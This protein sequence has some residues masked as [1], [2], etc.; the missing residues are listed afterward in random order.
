MEQSVNPMIP[1]GSG[2]ASSSPTPPA[3][4]DDEET[5]DRTPIARWNIIPFQRFSESVSIGVVAFHINGIDRVDF[6]A[7]GGEWVEARGM[8]ENPR[9]GVREYWGTLD[10]SSAAG[11]IEL[12]ALVWPRGSGTPLMLQN[13]I[14]D[15]GDSSSIGGTIGIHSMFLRAGAEEAQAYWVSEHGDD[16]APG[17]EG[18]PL[19]TLQ[20]AAQRLKSS[21]NISGGRIVVASSGVFEAPHQIGAKAMDAWLT[22]EAADGIDRDSIVIIPPGYE[23]GGDRLVMRPIIEKVRWRGVSFDFGTTVVY[24]SEDINDDG[25]GSFVWFDECYWYDHAGW[26]ESRSGQSYNVRSF[27]RGLYMTDSHVR[28]MLYGPCGFTLV[29][30]SLI[31]R[32]SGDSLANVK[33]AFENEVREQLYGVIPGFHCDVLQHWGEVENVI[34]FGLRASGLTDVQCILLDRTN[35]TFQNI[36]LVDLAFEVFPGGTV[37]TQLNSSCDHV[38]LWH[39]TIL[40]QRLALRDD[41]EGTSQFRADDVDLRNSVFE[42]LD[43]GDYYSSEL[44]EGVSLFHC[45]FAQ[46]SSLFSAGSE[47][48]ESITFDAID[49][50]FDGTAWSYSGSGASQIQDSAVFIPEFHLE[51]VSPDRGFVPE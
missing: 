2:F 26:S 11:E 21:G 4:G 18:M 31:E 51:D 15:V 50:M 43:S 10:L 20:A 32:V 28:D 23:S 36:A 49:V 7:D 44:P 14:G 37:A 1:V 38:L 45:H 30:N 16:N 35:S 13:G 3:F 9:T 47:G 40:N 8:T 22:I 41:F 46:P 19:A 42:R 12:R 6:S 25:R 24:Y 27:C 39:V 34:V 48:T 29:R 33:S 17:H 5:R